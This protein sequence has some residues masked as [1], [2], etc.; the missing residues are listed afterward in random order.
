MT[1]EVSLECNQSFIKRGYAKIKN[2]C[3][4]EPWVANELKKSVTLLQIQT[5]VIAF[6]VSFAHG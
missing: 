4:S 5:Q 2:L 3:R 1:N 6:C